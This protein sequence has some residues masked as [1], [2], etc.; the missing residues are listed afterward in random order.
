MSCDRRRT[1]RIGFLGLGTVG[2]GAFELLRRNRTDIEM[3]C[4]STIEVRRIAVRDV[5]KR[6]PIEAPSALLTADAS[7]VLDDPEI[8]IVCELIGGLD[9]AGEYVMRALRGGKSVVTANKELIARGGH[10]IMVEAGRRKLD[11]LFEGAVGGGIPIVQPMKNALAGNAFREVKGIVN[12]TT[13]YILTKMTRE[14]ASFDSVLREA[15]ARGFAEADPSSDVDGHDASY[16]IAILSSIAFNTRV[17]VE[18]VHVEGIRGVSDRDIACA[19]D[20]GY[21][22]KLL[23][24]GERSG[25]GIVVRVHPALLPADHPLA[26]VSDVYNAIYVRGDGVGDVMFYGQGAGMLATGSAVVGDIVDVCRNMAFGSTGRVPCTCFVDRPALPI[27]GI[28]TRYY[29]RMIVADR[30]GVLAAIAGVF[31]RHEVS[32]EM[33]RASAQARAES[34]WVTHSVRE[35]NLRAALAEAAGLPAVVSIESCIRVED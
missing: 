17:R 25:E 31:G 35:A 14:G 12:G 5:T 23:A 19:R 15:Q 30:P 7:E 2:C 20:L 27:D 6:R 10:E 4:G 26:A 28:E 8:D 21:V 33:M 29:V 22:V 18:D 16:K 9:P 24:I 34:V 13:N 3:R 32:I 11:F 1:V